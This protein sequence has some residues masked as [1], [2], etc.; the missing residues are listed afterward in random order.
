MD[1]YQ[2]LLLC[3]WIIL[4]LCNFFSSNHSDLTLLVPLHM[5]SSLY[6]CGRYER[7]ND[8]INIETVSF[9]PTQS[10]V[11]PCR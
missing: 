4:Y 10:G 8:C 2:T 3:I 1:R 9:F 11:F 6:L 7:T 5:P